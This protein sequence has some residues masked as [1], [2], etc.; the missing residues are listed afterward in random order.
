M[1]LIDQFDRIY[2]VNLP[3]RSDRRREMEAEL[4]RLGL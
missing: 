1:K 3:E 4:G 2:I